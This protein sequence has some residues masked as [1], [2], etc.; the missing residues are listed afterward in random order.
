MTI[1]E[2]DLELLSERRTCCSEASP[3]GLV[4][5]ALADAPTTVRARKTRQQSKL[6]GARTASAAEEAPKTRKAACPAPRLQRN[7]RVSSSAGSK[8]MF[9]APR[10]PPLI[11]SGGSRESASTYRVRTDGGSV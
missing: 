5:M 3:T 11:R 2:E 4:N 6:K 1:L 10:V 9:H 7:P 8:K